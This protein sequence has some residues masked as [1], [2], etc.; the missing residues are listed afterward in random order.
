MRKRCRFQ[1]TNV[2]R[3]SEVPSAEHPTLNVLS[4]TT[5][6]QASSAL[7]KSR[8]SIILPTIPTS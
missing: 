7:R 6:E 4:S 1:A 8:K 3:A 2:A 5:K